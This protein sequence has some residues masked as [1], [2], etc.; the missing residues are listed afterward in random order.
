MKKCNLSKEINNCTFCNKEKMEC[1][2][3]NTQCTFRERK[4]E[5]NS[6]YARKDRWYEK[7]YK[8]SRAKK[9]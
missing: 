2:N 5:G 4:I 8:D 3:E 1:N 6:K 7:Y 9:G